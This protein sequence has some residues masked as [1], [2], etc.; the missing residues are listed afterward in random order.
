MA[1]AN[2]GST[3]TSSGSVTV[4][5]T[6]LANLVIGQAVSGPGIAAGSVITALGSNAITLS[7]PLTASVAAAAKLS[8]GSGVASASAAETYRRSYNSYL[9]Q[10]ASALG[11]TGVIDSDS[12]FADLSGSG[13]WRVD[14]G[15]ASADGV[16]P[17]AALHQAAVTA[18]L[19][20]PGMFQAP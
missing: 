13:K 20:T 3:A 8:F 9:R 11:C 17:A 1:V 10:H 6:S 2:T 16:H 15:P 18:G 7:T 12:I 4:P 5:M 14:L 19:I